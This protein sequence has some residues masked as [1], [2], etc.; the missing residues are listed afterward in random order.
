MDIDHGLYE[1]D[2]WMHWKRIE[3]LRSGECAV[4]FPSTHLIYQDAQYRGFRLP[5]DAQ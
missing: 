4:P 1:T 2:R 5:S 3:R